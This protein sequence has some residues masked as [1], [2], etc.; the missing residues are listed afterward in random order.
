M[1]YHHVN[2]CIPE[3]GENES[4]T[5]WCGLLGFH[6]VEKPPSMNN[7]GGAWFRRDEIEMHVTPVAN[8]TPETQAH[9]CFV[10]QKIESLGKVLEEHKYPVTWDMTI[11]NRKR[12][13]TNDPAG[14]RLEF[15]E[16]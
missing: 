4:H 12:F 13:F 2:L 10:T 11:P 6:L 14:N 5:F 7:Q 16:G 1:R 3:G 9:P 8:F 15:M